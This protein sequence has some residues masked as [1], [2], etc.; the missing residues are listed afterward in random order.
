MLGGRVDSNGDK[1]GE[2]KLRD[3]K[4]VKMSLRKYSFKIW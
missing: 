3:A 4:I 1:W 2:Y